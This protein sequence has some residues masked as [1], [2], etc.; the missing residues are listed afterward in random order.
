M[1]VLSGKFDTK[2]KAGLC[3]SLKLRFSSKQYCT[4]MFQAISQEAE[5]SF[6]LAKAFHSTVLMALTEQVVGFT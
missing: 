4:L 3:C 1:I 5:W 6:T 2:M